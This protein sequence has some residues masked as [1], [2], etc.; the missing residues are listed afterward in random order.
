MLVPPYSIRPKVRLDALSDREMPYYRPSNN[1][2]VRFK[3]QGIAPVPG[4]SFVNISLSTPRKGGLS[5][6]PVGKM[7]NE[8][9]S[10][11]AFVSN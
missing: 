7:T 6:I 5:P 9:N 4:L 11:L 3:E 8:V 1:R 10:A 2:F